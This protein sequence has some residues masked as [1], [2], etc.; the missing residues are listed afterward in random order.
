MLGPAIRKAIAETLAGLVASI[1][2]TIEHSLSPH[3]LRWRLEAWRTGVPYAQI[4]LKHALIYRVEQVFLIHAETGLLLAHAWA[5]ELKASDP[6]L[7]SGMLTAIRDFVVDSFSRER[8]AG[9]LRR[10][11]VGELTV[12]VEQGPRAVLAAVVRGQA[13]TRCWSSCRT[14]SRRFTSSSPAPWPTS[15]ATRPRSSRRARCWKSVSPPSC[16]PTGPGSAEG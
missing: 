11:S 14:R 1:N 16:R 6:E 7:I 9:G 12:M 15:T 3:G 10:F 8:E 2:S 13:R 5:P 4:V